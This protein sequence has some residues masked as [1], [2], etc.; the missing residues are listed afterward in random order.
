[1]NLTDL[2]RKDLMIQVPYS[3]LLAMFF[4]EQRI[5]IA[6]FLMILRELNGTMLELVSIFCKV[7]CPK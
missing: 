7:D 5:N 4:S 2:F 1:M 6:S 3:T